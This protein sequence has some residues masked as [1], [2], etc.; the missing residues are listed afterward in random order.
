MSAETYHA[1]FFWPDRSESL[2]QCAQRAAAFFRLLESCDPCF[3]RW[4]KPRTTHKR[5]GA[6]FEP[7][8]DSLY[9]VLKDTRIRG[10]KDHSAMEDMG[11]GIWLWNGKSGDATARVN[12]TCGAHPCI[13]TVGLPVANRCV[14]ELPA[15][16]VTGERILQPEALLH[17]I[18]AIVGSWD[19]D[20]GR[21]ASDDIYALMTGEDQADIVGWFNFLSDRYVLPPRLPP[22]YDVKHVG[23]G[24]VI[25]I[26]TVERFSALNETHVKLVRELLVLLREAGTLTPKAR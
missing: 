17:I 10:D 12:I 14:I 22:E 21:I 5:T 19:A 25:A 20:W 13:P 1:S 26:T 4:V 18:S 2:N 8:F 16:G 11:Y 7:T 9:N 24:N 6:E 23:N 15:S 3:A